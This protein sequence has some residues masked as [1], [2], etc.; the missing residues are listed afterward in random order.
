MNDIFVKGTRYEIFFGIKDKDS[1]EEILDAED[2]QQILTEICS[3]KN[4]CFSLLTQKGGYNHNK[5]F[6][7][8]T[9][10]RVILI[11]ASENEITLIGERLKKAVNTDTILITKSEVE[12]AFL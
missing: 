1:Y 9:S 11:G 10:F 5:G 8:E 3:E 12:Y 2:I 4:I 7:N 6:T